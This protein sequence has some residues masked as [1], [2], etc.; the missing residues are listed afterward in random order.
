MKN[1]IIVYFLGTLTLFASTYII[2]WTYQRFSKLEVIRGW[3]LCALLI[4]WVLAHLIPFTIYAFF[5]E[6]TRYFPSYAWMGA[7]EWLI[8]LLVSFIGCG[9]LLFGYWLGQ[10]AGSKHV[11]I[12]NLI[13]YSAQSR[14]LI[15][16][17]LIFVVM[18]LIPLFLIFFHGIEIRFEHRNIHWAEVGILIRFLMFCIPAAIISSIIW[19][20]NNIIKIICIMALIISVVSAVACGQ[21]MVLLII[22]LSVIVFW[23]RNNIVIR[24]FFIMMFLSFAVIFSIFISIQYRTTIDKDIPYSTAKLFLTD[25]G[26]MNVMAYTIRHTNLISSELIHPP[27]LSS[28]L[29]W[30]IVSIP[31]SVWDDKPYPANLQFSHWFRYNYNP[32]YPYLYIQGN[33]GQNEFGFIEE[34][35]LNFGCLGLFF[36]CIIGYIISIVELKLLPFPVMAT[37]SWLFSFLGFIYSFNAVFMLLL[38][39]LIFIIAHNLMKQILYTR[40]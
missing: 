1:D 39:L 9:F 4:G 23:W 26:R 33:I 30:A 11:I 19:R 31:R 20:W 18:Q 37:W 34:A 12:P 28:Y 29:Y 40:E 35:L 3:L 17:L 2:Y 21:R 14:L 38:P 32:A 36:I 24:K 13:P 6:S 10:S 22:P 16:F 7:D 8:G 27:L 25:L 5:P 15:T